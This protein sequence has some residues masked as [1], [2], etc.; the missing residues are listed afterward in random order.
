MYIYIYTHIQRCS[1]NPDQAERRS[2]NVEHVTIFGCIINLEWFVACSYARLFLAGVDGSQGQS[3]F[4]PF[5]GGSI[6]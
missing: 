1:W 2:K 4:R 3:V 6:K 5:G